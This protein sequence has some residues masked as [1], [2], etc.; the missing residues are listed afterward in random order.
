MWMYIKD[1]YDRRMN[2]AISSNKGPFRNSRSRFLQ[3]EATVL[4]SQN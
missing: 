1:M 3:P 4:G 2:A